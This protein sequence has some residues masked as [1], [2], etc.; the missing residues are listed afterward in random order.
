M[1]WSLVEKMRPNFQSLEHVYGHQSYFCKS[2]AIWV[3]I[4]KLLNNFVNFRGT[5]NL[6]PILKMA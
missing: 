3:K 5:E 2:H 6:S 4:Y 1:E